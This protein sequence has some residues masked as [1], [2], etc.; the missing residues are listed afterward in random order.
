MKRRLA[1]VVAALTL[2]AAVPAYAA[3]RYALIVTGA[4]GAPQ[5]AERYEAW[6]TAFVSLFRDAFG[7]PADRVI[8]LAEEESAGVRRA[9][10]DNVRAALA[11]LRK[12]AG[13][14][15]VVAVLL[16]GHGTGVDREDAK[17]NL[18]G[19]DLT[20]GEWAAL[21]KPIAAR[22]VFINTTGA[23]FP[24][25]EAVAGPDR[26]VLT[27][28][29]S[30][31]QQFDTVFPGMLAAALRNEAAD[32][33]KNGR[34]SVWEA[35][36]H[37]SAAVRG[38]FEQRGQLA[39]ERPL[40][41]DSGDGIGREADPPPAPAQSRIPG[42]SAP[43]ASPAPPA[44]KPASNDGTLARVT[45]FAPDVP[46]TQSAD[47]ELTRLLTRK[48]ELQTALE[49]LKARKES[50]TADAYD[51]ALEKIVLELARIDREIRSKT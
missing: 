2:S 29:D 8:V 28:T 42:V 45:Y 11:D 9:T 32:A 51:A 38:F 36:S 34:V 25:L 5:Y 24:F 41:D 20:A 48:A 17:F 49:L 47:A 46:I 16:V 33:D 10:A 12:R 35:F 22:V 13:K 23:S 37:A 26:V 7:Y 4:S 44:P 6:R 39:T 1:A 15:D 31:A 27:A 18:V 19:P 50:M 14:D 21:I 3:D 30:A 40:L 43:P